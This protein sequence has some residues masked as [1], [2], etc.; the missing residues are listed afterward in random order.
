M[1]YLRI[2]STERNRDQR[3][4]I[5]TQ[6]TDAINDLFYNPKS[7]TTREELREHTTV[8]FMP[9]A[10]DNLFIGA[11]TPDERGRQ[12]VTVEL[13]HRGVNTKQD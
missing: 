13:V 11:R 3:R 12:D 1:P 6:L 10:R 7:P 8:H 9:Y 5:A 2:T 4:A